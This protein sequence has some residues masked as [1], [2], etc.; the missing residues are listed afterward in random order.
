M[1]CRCFILRVL[2]LCLQSDYFLVS[3]THIELS[4]HILLTYLLICK[5]VCNSCVPAGDGF[6]MGNVGGILQETWVVLQLRPT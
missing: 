4:L 5:Y 1:F 2:S 6:Y 3:S